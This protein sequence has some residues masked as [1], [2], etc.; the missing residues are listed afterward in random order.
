M[1]FAYHIHVHIVVA[2]P[3]A[4]ISS[5]IT[6]FIT[7]L[8]TFIVTRKRYTKHSIVSSE[9]QLQSPGGGPVYDNQSGIKTKIMNYMWKLIKHM[10]KSSYDDII[11]MY[12]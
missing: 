10:D 12:N 5:L 1:F 11:R 8:I 9:I 2:V 7:F 4:V 3:V 6:G